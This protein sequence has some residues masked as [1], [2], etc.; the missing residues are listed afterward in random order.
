MSYFYSLPYN[1]IYA[2]EYF[3]DNFNIEFSKILEKHN[4][5][6]T[7]KLPKH[8]SSKDATD[9]LTPEII[10]KVKEIYAEDVDFYDR[11]SKS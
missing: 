2:K 10:K 9:T 6:V 4:I 8:N 3:R 1:E 7:N 5:L 11:L